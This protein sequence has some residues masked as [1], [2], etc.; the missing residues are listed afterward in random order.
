MSPADDTRPPVPTG[1]LRAALERS[2]GRRVAGLARRPS[3]YRS[4]FA[5]EELDVALADGTTLAM[6]FKDLG[7]RSL[8]AAGRRAKP[9]FLHDPRREIAT[10]QHVLAPLGLGTAA[11]HGASAD[12]PHGRYWL[13]LERVPAAGLNQV[14]ALGAWAAAATWLAELH[15]RFADPARLRRLARVARLC[16]WD[17]AALAVWASR[18]RAFLPT[19]V[20]RAARRLLDRLLRQYGRVL[21]RL[22]ALPQ[23]FLHGEYYAPNVLV[24]EAPGGWRVC[25]VDWETAAM[26]PAL[27][28]L[29]AL[30]AGLW[31]DGRGE[32]LAL[33]YRAALCPGLRDR[34]SADQFLESLDYCRL[35]QAVQ[36]LGWSPDWSPPA[37]QAH[38]WPDEA[39]RLV[40]R[41]GL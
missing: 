5:L 8:G 30:T 27:L 3:A 24:G 38:D 29:A 13:F 28:D 36:W 35:H 6:V 17:R 20:P 18:A 12:A 41:L 26:G 14:G 16:V 23:V 15:S 4:S 22:L 1:A 32:A 40:K 19:A 11:F 21:D 25:P 37:Q 39:A 31:S 34:L 10:Y 33:A 9:P 7:W 2:L